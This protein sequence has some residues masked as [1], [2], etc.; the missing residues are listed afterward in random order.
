MAEP[1]SNEVLRRKARAG[2]EEHQSRVMSPARAM[3]LALSRAADDLFGLALSVSGV[4][5]EQLGQEGM[6]RAVDDEMLLVVLDGPRGAVGAVAVD[7]AVLAGII[8]QQTMGCVVK[9]EPEARAPTDTD[10]ALISP[11]VDMLLEGIALN[12]GG[13]DGEMTAGFHFGARI[14]TKRHLSLIVEAPDFH[15]LRA[16][17]ELDG[18][19][20]RGELVLVVPVQLPEAAA[21]RPLSF[22]QNNAAE[23]GHSDEAGSIPAKASFADSA[24][25]EAEACLSAVIHRQKM[26]LGAFGN[27]KP[28]DRL[29]LPALA[30]D[31]VVLGE[32]ANSKLG[33]CRLG[34][35]GGLRAVQLRFIVRP[36]QREEVQTPAME[37]GLEYTSAPMTAAPMPQAPDLSELSDLPDTPDLPDLPDLP[38]LPDLP[39]L[40]DLPGFDPDLLSEAG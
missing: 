18:G 7:L 22:A 33:P 36:S 19:A 15:V 40:S 20:K 11:L 9:G 31:N 39:D 26:T 16:Q 14:E 32:G 30:L 10:A 35:H 38:E 34:Q 29:P 5:C 2:R 28:G 12:L 21:A 8:E 4:Q 13:R 23:S 3:R 24:M 25:M 27:L 37:T 1:L 6:L 17:L